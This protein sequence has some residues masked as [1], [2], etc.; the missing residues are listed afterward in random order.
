LF[1]QRG[2]TASSAS[3]LLRSSLLSSCSFP[4]CSAGCAKS[5]AA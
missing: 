4:P 3:F 5:P 1:N 2:A